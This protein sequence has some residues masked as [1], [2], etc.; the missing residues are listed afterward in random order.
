MIYL[1]AT[2]PVFILIA[3][4]YVTFI[5][6]YIPKIEREQRETES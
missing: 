3:L 1:L 4:A 5:E 6:F 2:V